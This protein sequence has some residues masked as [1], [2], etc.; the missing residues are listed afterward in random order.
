MVVSILTAFPD[1][2]F[3]RKQPDAENVPVSE[4]RR[5]AEREGNVVA[6]RWLARRA[7]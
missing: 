3:V 4:V 7:G 1:M 6:Q 2:Q 5:L